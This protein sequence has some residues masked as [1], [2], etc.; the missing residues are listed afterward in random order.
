[1]YRVLL[2]VTLLVLTFGFTV[3]EYA[4]AGERPPLSPVRV[5]G[6]LLAGGIGGLA[7]FAPPLILC[8]GAE[9]SEGLW[10]AYCLPVTY[11]LFTTAGVYLVG[12]IGDETGSFLAT[13]AGSSLG[14]VA[15][16]IVFVGGLEVFESDTLLPYIVLTTSLLPSAGAVIGFNLSRKY[17]SHADSG[18]EMNSCAPPIYFNLVRGRF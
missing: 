4:W 14:A 6:E 5:A 9:T 8:I 3:P 2:A 18:T 16:I 13:L 15:G 17:N 7:G 12:C 10:P 11:P 1:M